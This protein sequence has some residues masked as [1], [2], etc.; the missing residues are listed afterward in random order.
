MPDAVDEGHDALNPDAVLGR[1]SI[2][3]YILQRTRNCPEFRRE[4][5]WPDCSLTT[6]CCRGLG[7]RRRTRSTA[8]AIAR[9]GRRRAP[10]DDERHR[11]GIPG[12]PTCT[13]TPSSAAWRGS[14]RQ[15]HAADSFWTWRELMYRFLGRMS[16][17]RH[18]GD[19][20]VG[21][22][23]DAGDRLHPRSA[24]FTTSITTSRARPT[25]TSAKW[26]A[27]I[28]AAAQATG[29]GLTLLP[30][31]YTH[32]GF[33]GR[34]PDPGQRRFINDLDR[35]CGAAGAS[36]RAVQRTARRGVGIAPH[37]LRAVT[38][39]E[40]AAILPLA[41][42]GPVHIHVAEQT[43]E[44]EDCIAWSGRRPVQWLLDHARGRPPLVPDPR[45]PHDRRRDPAT[46]A[47]GAV[48]GLCPVTEAN[49]GDGI[50]NAPAFF[51]TAARSASARIP[52]C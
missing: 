35:I 1:R 5:A 14:P 25:P 30:V 27:R 22:Y 8:G 20:G 38:P 44:V 11:I 51:G 33:G 43:K 37:S 52:T 31:F 19:R 39:D 50:F 47:S 29:I 18:R 34:A 9:V 41:Q 42:G 3:L 4:K 16:A 2:C 12:M 10:P 6:R 21:L 36:R 13:A 23:R 17:R 26:P 40:L 45:D 48:A 15:A 32:A 24:N 46:R 7:A 28:A 49:L